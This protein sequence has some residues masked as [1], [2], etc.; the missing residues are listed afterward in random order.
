M[1]AIRNFAP[2]LFSFRSFSSYL[3]L[4]CAETIRVS[5]LKDAALANVN[6]RDGFIVGTVSHELANMNVRRPDLDRLVQAV[7]TVHL[8]KGASLNIEEKTIVQAPITS[9]EEEEYRFALVDN[10]VLISEKT[11]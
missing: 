2:Q 3:K 11:S 4:P 5:M 8:F 7:V 10:L 6:T 1:F 9:A